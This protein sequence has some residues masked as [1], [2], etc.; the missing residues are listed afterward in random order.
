MIQGVNM[1]NNSKV[2]KAIRLAMMF[3]ASAAAAISAPT[4]A[5]A[6]DEGVEEVERIEV[7]GSAIKRTDMEGALP[8]DIITKADILSSGVTSVPDLMASLPSMQGFTSAGE[9]VGGGGGGVQTASLRDLGSQYTLV[10]LNGRRMASS[11][12][13]G[14]IDLNSIP[15]S[16][17]ERVEILKDGAS[18]LYGSDA[19]AGV[20]NF[21]MKKDVQETTV[22]VRYD[23][24]KDTSSYNFSV[25][26]GYGDLSNDGFN[27]MVAYSR[28]GKDSLAAVDRDF[29]RTGFINFEHGGQELVAFSGSVNAIPANAYYDYVDANGEE[30]S[31]TMSPY[32]E[33]NGACH[34]TSAPSG[35]AC[36]FDYTSTL[37]IQPESTRDN[38]FLQG[39]IEIN[40]DMEAY[41][42]AS[43][44][45]FEMT[46]KIA[47]YPTGTFTLP[48]SSGIVQEN[49]VPYL[50]AE[51]LAGLTDVKARWRT[52]PGG[53]RTD[54][55]STTTTHF[56]AGVRGVVSDI[57]YDFAITSADAE[58]TQTRVTGYPLTTEFMALVTSGAVNIFGAPEDLSAEQNQMVKDTMFSGAW[59]ATDTSMF[60]IEGKA[61]TEIAELDAGSVY[62]AV[63]FDYRSTDYA[64]TNAAG[65]NAEV[66]LFESAGTEFAL[67]RETY[68]AFAEIIVPIFEDFE[69]TAALR[70]D[71][72]GEVTDTL[73]TGNQVV[74]DSTDDT[75]YKVTASYRPSDSWLLRASYGT[76]FKAPSMRQIAE[77]L[78]EFGVTSTS[79]ACPAG[80]AADL[81][82]YCYSDD[83]QYDVY[84]QGY[85][86]LKPETSTQISGGFVWSGENDTSFSIDYFNI[87]MKDQVTRLTQDQIF[88]DAA[89]YG[90]LYT[91]KIDQGTGDTVLAIIQSAVNIGQSNTSG[92]DWS[93]T[94]M[95]EFSLGSLRT[96]VAGTYM[97]ESENL[98]SGTTDVWDSS[99]G[100]VGT[101]AS[102]TFRNIVML[103]NSFTHGDFTH[104]L[105]FKA[106]SGYQDAAASDS[107]NVAYANDWTASVDGDLVVKHVPVYMTIDYRLSYNITNNFDASFGILNLMDK[108]PP[109][110]L[111]AA[112][113]HQA[114][115]DPRYA[116]PYGRTFYMTAN[117]TF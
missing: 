76:G 50:T 59:D 14:T 66:V 89:L 74:N 28:D 47:P 13:G 99:L 56:V 57:D 48:I 3:G 98:R 40:D 53:N 72:I 24:P 20:V 88:G 4:F 84:R 108:E 110:T 46:T 63:G 33:K 78:V 64:L 116:S 52:L 34:N 39:L 75:T 97:I 22:S 1:Y 44:S 109:F 83:L 54:E 49:V 80:L 86:K 81:A 65:Q 91:T 19:I 36:Q 45:K 5:A 67:E 107:F 58:R 23:Q 43:V 103:N 62:V 68:G 37:Q 73:R 21:I 29:A 95:N 92:I 113:G 93:Y 61:S 77:P 90:D 115:Y 100:K 31:G 60:S 51:E 69:M 9:S 117:Y 6:A 10:L 26:T 2:A 32:N 15:L 7:T 11:D 16:A 71:N 105:N 18:A 12:S 102:V 38:L 35:S 104:N 101:N 27:I 114:G 55:L 85:A 111:N 42:T 106:R 87:E 70:Y 30:Q 96:L 79:Y 82:Q 112:A 94:M 17:I 25:T 41:A 8:V